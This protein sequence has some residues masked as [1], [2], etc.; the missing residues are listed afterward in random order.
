MNLKYQAIPGFVQKISLLKTSSLGLAPY[1]QTA[2]IL[3]IPLTA[4][5][6]WYTLDTWNDR[7]SIPYHP[8]AI[9]LSSPWITRQMATA[10]KTTPFQ[11][12]L[13]NHKFFGPLDCRDS[14]YWTPEKI[15]C[16]YRN[17]YYQ[18]RR[19]SFKRESRI[20]DEIYWK[21]NWKSRDK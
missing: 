2:D 10:V 8:R 20:P 19:F 3:P 6:F 21:L 13:G 14:V 12:W 7:Q 1:A 5:Q 17:L 18:D 16:P 11:I 9:S 15:Q 4:A